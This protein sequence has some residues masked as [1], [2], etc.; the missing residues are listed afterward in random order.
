MMRALSWLLLPVLALGCGGSSGTPPKT[1]ERET[2]EAE[3]TRIS[4]SWTSTQVDRSLLS[5]PSPISVRAGSRT[6]I[7][8]F[9]DGQAHEELVISEQFDLRA[10]G[11]IRCETRFRHAVRVRFGHKS[12][13]PAVEVVRPPLAGT[14]SCDAP[15]PEP[16]LVEP[17]RRALFVL[18]SDQ[19]VAV[20][21]ALDERIYRPTSD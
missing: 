6:S 1:V 18:G 19:L 4:R 10:G 17:E 8:T 5:P 16:T 15:P 12:G 9:T 21:P 14:R 20:E 11:R 7:V 13:E 3:V 2:A